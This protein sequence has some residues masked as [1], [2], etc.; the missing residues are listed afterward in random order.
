MITIRRKFAILLMGV[1]IISIIS[2][3]FILDNFFDKSFKEYISKDMNEIYEISAK[4][5]DDYIVI[6]GMNKKEMAIGD[7][8]DKSMKFIVD[9]VSSQGVLY[10]LEGKI[11]ATGV[12]GE[13]EIDFN[14]LKELPQ[15]FDLVKEN[16]TMLDIESKQGNILGKLSYSIYGKENKA[17]GV[18]VLIKDYSSEFLRNKSTKNLI[19][20]IVGIL[21]TIIFVAIYYLASTMVKPII[22]LKDKVSEVCKGKY[23]EKIDINSRDEIGVLINTFNLM[24]EKLKVKDMQEKNIF[25]NITHE[26]KTPLTNISGYAQIL[27]EDDFNDEDFRKK[28]L[29]RI[30]FESK[31]MH[32]LVVS[33]LNVSKQSSDLEEYSFEDVN[34]KNIVE[35]I[36]EMQLPKFTKKDLKVDVTSIEVM[37]KGNKQYLGILF[38]NLIDNGIKYSKVGT[39]VKINIYEE[40]NYSIFTILTEGKEIPIDMKEKIFEPFIKIENKGFSLKDSHG[41]G[42]YICKNIVD[43]HSGIIDVNLEGNKTKFIVKIPKH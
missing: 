29:D 21:F 23:P 43:G 6:N 33:L 41:L 18:L 32:E 26:L 11:I 7:L 4:N 35:Q 37:V 40:D 13:K 16:K 12:T 36:I 42:L 39:N 17:I 25:R 27:R 3:N 28:S 9:R 8:S 5:L 34:I 30:I 31:R 15:S 38:S 10:D 20:I 22:I 19:N 14:I 24:S 2:F 1:F